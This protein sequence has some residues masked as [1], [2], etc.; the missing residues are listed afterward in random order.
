MRT[1]VRRVR[2]QEVISRVLERDVV[3]RFLRP[4]LRQ[5]DFLRLSQTSKGCL[6]ESRAHLDELVL[7]DGGVT[8]ALISSIVTQYPTLRK[9]ELA[10]DEEDQITD[11]ALFEVARL[12]KLRDLDLDGYKFLSE[13]NVA[14]LS[15]IWNRLESLH[16]R[17][18]D[19]D[20]VDHWPDAVVIKVAER[21]TNLRFLELCCDILTDATMTAV[22]LHCVHLQ[23][24]SLIFVDRLSDAAIVTIVDQCVH[25]R[26]IQ[27]AECEGLTDPVAALENC[28]TLEEIDIEGIRITDASIRNLG[29]GG[30]L[31][32][33]RMTD[34]TK[35]VEIS[36]ASVIPLLTRCIS[37]RTLSLQGRDMAVTNAS[38]SAIARSCPELRELELGYGLNIHGVS[39][40]LLTSRCS[41]LRKLALSG[42]DIGDTSCEAIARD[43]GDLR[44]LE[45]QTHQITN[46]G[47]AQLAH[48]PRLRAFYLKSAS[49]SDAGIRAF[50]RL[51]S[52]NL[53]NNMG[54]TPSGIR[55]LLSRCPNL[56][57]LSL[58]QCLLFPP[59]EREKIRQSIK[60]SHPAVYEDMAHH[61]DQRA[62]SNEDTDLRM[63]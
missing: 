37:L 46:R 4:W 45:L 27:L 34:G 63:R 17:E 53:R 40:A 19:P 35:D 24:L 2:A 28:Q 50:S 14:A 16:L 7:C 21:C 52:F 29:R 20:S 44:S 59:D 60:E 56:Q 48:C 58:F 26:S 30:A 57:E 55:A 18:H 31:T 38:V 9:L 49:V 33:I 62:Y 61:H 10:C 39:V 23:S 6:R 8:D 11:A 13:A 43:L 1:R 15:E 42:V 41:K 47:L 25:L 22:A 36:D 12:S 5:R 3:A 51:E 32:S 54:V